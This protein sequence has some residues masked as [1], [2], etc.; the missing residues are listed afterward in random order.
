MTTPMKCEFCDKRGLPILLVRDAVAP[1]GGR[2]PLTPS[3]PI[4]L[5]PTAAHYTKRLLRSGYVNVFDE[6]RRR[7][8]TYF[9]TSDNHIL[10]LM[11]GFNVTPLAPKK[12]FNCLD[13]SHRAIASCITIPDPLNASRVW[14]GFSDVLWTDA[15]RKAN[16]N[17]DYRNRHMAVIDIASA[18]RGNQAPHN[19]ISQLES[20][21]AEYA[22]TPP[23]ARKSFEWCPFDMF[24]RHG[25]AE[26]LQKEFERLRPGA[27]LIVTLP[28]PAGIVHELA[29]LMKHNLDLFLNGN[30]ENRRNLAA[31]SAI[32]AIEAA[33]R[34]QAKDAEFTAA[35]QLI[36]QQIKANPIGHWFSETTRNQTKE[37]HKVTPGDLQSAADKAWKKY[38]DKFNDKKRKLWLAPFSEKLKAY[39]EVFIALLALSHVGWMKSTSFADYF[40][41]NYDPGNAESGAVYTKVITNCITATQDKKACSDLYDKLLQGDIADK[42]NF[43]FR[44]MIL[45]QAEISKA[46][47]K[48]AIVDIGW[49]N[50]PWDNILAIHTESLKQLS[51]RS[52]DVAAQFVIQVAGPITRVLTKII[53]GGNGLRGVFMAIGLVQGHPIVICDIVGTKKQFR[54]HLIRQLLSASGEVIAESQMQ[55]S[56][57]AG[58]KQLEVEGKAI[59]GSTH[60][61]WIVG[62]D[63][64]KIKRMPANLT[65]QQRA[66]WLAQSI[67]TVE[68]LDELNLNRWRNIITHNMRVGVIAGLLQIASLTKLVADEE[69][70]L[71]NEKTDAI[72][73]RW[74]GVATLAGT[75]SEVF[76][77]AVVQRAPAGMRFGQGLSFSLGKVA[78]IGGQTASILAG[79]AVAILDGYK[80]YQEHKEGASGLVVVAYIG[81]AV[82]GAALSL[83]LIKLVA[84]GAAAIP[85]IGILVVLLIGIGIL[86]E[87]IKDNPIQDWLERCPWGNLSEQRYPNMEIE[88]AQFQQA[89]KG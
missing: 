60:K 14:I 58:L 57:R 26:R 6:A 81:S 63:R 18:L 66:N 3:L 43:L 64:E 67:K 4:E 76:G 68:G 71:E 1:A 48:A 21:V 46:V 38:A 52:H 12:Q 28:D 23:Q 10:K 47:E 2:A 54:T 35:D 61:R 75:A 36:A 59:E 20:I 17:A 69:K 13:E 15:V 55:H 32:D 40:E 85:I 45:N 53:D 82:A 9:V 83:A 78:Q 25:R 41:C 50:I 5:A 88:Q 8:E 65:P 42:N 30:Q 27:G 72:G 19:S 49:K 34:S 33:V 84:L 56:V 86:L 87:Y 51:A 16:E 7:W 22:M 29:F 73:R 11:Q 44:A 31:S 37:L 74:A 24:S 89:I 70:S 79:L 77:N 80:A 39:D 62:A